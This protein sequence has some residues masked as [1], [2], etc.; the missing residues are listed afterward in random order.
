MIAVGVIPAVWVL[1]KITVFQNP[2]SAPSFSQPNPVA[3][4]IAAGQ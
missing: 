3:Q 4:Q 2:A 1:L